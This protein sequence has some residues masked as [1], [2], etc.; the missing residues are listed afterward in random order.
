MRYWVLG[1]GRIGISAVYYLIINEPNASIVVTD[2]SVA[3]LRSAPDKLI[4]SGVSRETIESRVTFLPLDGTTGLSEK[5]EAGDVILS[6]LPYSLNFGAAQTAVN[7]GCHYA[8]LGGNIDVTSEVLSLHPLAKE[9]GV[10]LIPDCGLAPGLVGILAMDGI[11]LFDEVDSVKLRVGG[12]PQ[13][14][15]GPFKYSLVFSSEGLVNEYVEPALALRN[16]EI[17]QLPPMSELEDIPF[18]PPW[19]HLEAFTTSGGTSTLP[20]TLRGKVRNL[21]YK[22]VRYPGHCEKVRTL[23]DCGLADQTIWNVPSGSVRPREI[24][25]EIF[26]RTCPAD[27]PD[28][29]LL[30]VELKGMFQHQERRVIYEM[31]DMFDRSTGFSAMQR[32]TG[33]PLAIIGAMIGN[34]IITERGALHQE[35]VVP[36][37][38]LLIQL[39]KMGVKITRSVH[40]SL[41]DEP[42]VYQREV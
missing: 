28:V 17:R 25:E 24:L 37:E 5:L 7:C 9:R 40:P 20:K 27:Q 21:D 2:S 6:C 14:P 29:V 11:P 30:R 1:C 32:T 33:F 35:L 38:P 22:T 42:S 12:L 23:L 4:R 31:I 26:R 19:G 34:Q 41:D 16:Y 13:T 36:A 15:E 10:T 18:S 8:D 3:V 39:A